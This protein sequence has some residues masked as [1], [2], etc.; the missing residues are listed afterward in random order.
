VHFTSI[1]QESGY[2]TR[3]K[4]DLVPFDVIRPSKARKPPMSSASYVPHQKPL[5]Q[6]FRARHQPPDLPISEH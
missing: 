6:M 2:K 4:G 1:R 3:K 5:R